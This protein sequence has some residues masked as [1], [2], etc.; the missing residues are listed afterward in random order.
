MYVCMY[1]C[2]Y[3][4]IYMYKQTNLYVPICMYVHMSVSKYVCMYGC[5]YLCMPTRAYDVNTNMIK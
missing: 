3:A 5:M 2:M 4:C 1:V